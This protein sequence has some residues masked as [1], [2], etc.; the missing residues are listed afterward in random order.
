[1]SY[2]TLASQEMGP[3]S[4]RSASKEDSE[5]TYHKRKLRV[6]SIPASFLSTRSREIRDQLNTYI[7]LLEGIH[8]LKELLKKKDY[9]LTKMDLKDVYFMIPKRKTFY[10]VLSSES[11]RSVHL[12][13]LRYRVLYGFSPRPRDQ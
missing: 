10:S 7:L 6:A 9:W 12:P 3:D 8:T 13:A 2:I 1:M 4:P 5:R 11:S